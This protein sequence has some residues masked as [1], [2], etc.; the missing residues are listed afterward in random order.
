M[1]TAPH[2]RWQRVV[3]SLPGVALGLVI[4]GFPTGVLAWAGWWI[5]RADFLE[6]H[7]LVADGV[8]V[9]GEAGKGL[10]NDSDYCVEHI[11]FKDVAGRLRHPQRLSRNGVD[12][13]PNVRPGAL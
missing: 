2:N 6:A 10:D 11:E 5:H 7:G 9:T 13:Q 3:R 1:T 8:V 12:P 4:L